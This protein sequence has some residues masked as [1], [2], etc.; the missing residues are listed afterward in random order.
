MPPP[1]RKEPSV[2][3]DLTIG[4][5]A[6]AR[7]VWL[8]TVRVEEGAD[9]ESW[10]AYSARGPESVDDS[11]EYLGTVWVDPA[12]VEWCVIAEF[13]KV[14]YD[15]GLT[16]LRYEGVS[17]PTRLSDLC[18]AGGLHDWGTLEEAGTGKTWA[19]CEECG[20]PRPDED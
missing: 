1:P 3:L 11:D 12:G 8:S 19:G 13:V 7:R 10:D 17:E 15:D 4:A 20:A 9:G 18:P 6:L 16:D 5:F 2:L 14:T